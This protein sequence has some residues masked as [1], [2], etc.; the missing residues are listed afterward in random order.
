M[1]GFGAETDTNL[2][3]SFV[4]MSLNESTYIMNAAAQSANDWQLKPATD[5]S[6]EQ[7]NWM[8]E[9][10]RHWLPTR[11]I[12]SSLDRTSSVDDCMSP[13]RGDYNNNQMQSPPVNNAAQWPKPSWNSMWDNS[14]TSKIETFSTEFSMNSFGNMLLMGMDDIPNLSNDI[15]EVLAEFKNNGIIV[16]EESTDQMPHFKSRCSTPIADV[17][18]S[19]IG[20]EPNYNMYHHYQSST[21]QTRKP[22]HEIQMRNRKDFT[23]KSNIGNR[24]TNGKRKTVSKNKV[25]TNFCVFCK[26]NGSSPEIY[27]SHTVK[28]AKGRCLC[29]VLRKYECP[30]CHLDGDDAHTIKYCKEKPIITEE[31]M[32]RADLNPPAKP[33]RY[34]MCY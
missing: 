12:E 8:S 25:E 28:D 22:L 31:D 24:I 5:K 19:P 14:T 27:Y 23:Q 10:S 7:N 2:L 11:S 16:D 3:E 15:D 9:N 17:P 30:I 1:W 6:R 29:P 26:N 33:P 20:S 13:N 34:R 18:L 32:R 21:Y 4:N